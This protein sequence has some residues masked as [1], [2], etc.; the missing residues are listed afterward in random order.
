MSRVTHMR[1]A[2]TSAVSADVYLGPVQC[3]GCAVGRRCGG[4]VACSHAGTRDH[5][6][7]RLHLRALGLGELHSEAARRL[8][9]RHRNRQ[10]RNSRQRNGI[11]PQRQ[12]LSIDRSRSKQA[13]RG[14]QIRIAGLTSPSR[15]SSWLKPPEPARRSRLPPRMPYK[16][17]RGVLWLSPIAKQLIHTKGPRLTKRPTAPN[18]RV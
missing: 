8:L 17:P 6:G 7:S 16:P 11:S 2:N 3:D 18:A 14:D 5:D 4:P 9:P 13:Q 10:A 12:R 15:A 1:S